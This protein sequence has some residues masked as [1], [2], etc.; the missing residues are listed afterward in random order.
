MSKVK[1]ASKRDSDI[2]Y[3][4]DALS[5][6]ESLVAALS[7]MTEAQLEDALKIETSKP[8]DEQRGDVIKRIHSRLTRV[9]SQRE[10]KEYLS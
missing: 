9:R 8:R 5:T 1:R 3:T 2:S 7:G 4:I 6:W 10:L